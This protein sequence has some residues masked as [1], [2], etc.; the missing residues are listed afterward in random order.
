MRTLT[1]TKTHMRC[2]ERQL[3]RPWRAGPPSAIAAVTSPLTDFHHHPLTTPT[4]PRAT[5]QSPFPSPPDDAT[6]GH[7]S[8][9]DRRRPVVGTTPLPA[10]RRRLVSV[11]SHNRRPEFYCCFTFFSVFVWFLV[12]TLLLPPPGPGT[13]VAVVTRR[14]RN[15]NRYR[16]SRLKI[17]R[18]MTVRVY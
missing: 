11:F 17:V 12:S 14:Y 5:V 4:T 9:H 7:S 10:V 18:F 15:M 2:D 6:T 8:N 13:V 1:A 16:C 3:L